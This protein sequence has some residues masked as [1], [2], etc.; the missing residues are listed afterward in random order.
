[1]T[2]SATEAERA[3]S[4][5]K[6]SAFYGWAQ[7]RGIA[8]QAYKALRDAFMDGYDNGQAARAI[9]QAAAE[10]VKRRSVLAICDAYESGMGHGLQ[11]DGHS[12]GA[13]W[14]DPE[15]VIAYEL[16]YKE[17]ADRISAAP[18]RAPSIDSYPV[19]PMS[20][21][22][23]GSLDYLKGW[24]DCLAAIV[25]GGVPS[26]D[27]ATEKDAA[28]YRAIRTLMESAKG[29]A[30]IEVNQYLAYY[31]TCEPGEEVK[32]QWYPDTPIGFYTIEAST[33]DAMA[34]RAIAA[35]KGE[36]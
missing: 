22:M 16:G 3:P 23:C 11:R 18:D 32:L 10:P 36:G 35:M 14:G 28:R 19:E 27:S 33:F 29:S 5:D 8:G 15:C 24:N 12:S 9:P 34:D 2:N 25:A 17:G 21:S 7:K 31:D 13:I 6:E 4:V 1:M 30:S 20:M 26:I